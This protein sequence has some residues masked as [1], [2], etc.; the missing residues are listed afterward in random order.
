MDENKRQK[1]LEIGYRIKPSC[2][3]CLHG[4]FFIGTNWGT[5]GIYTYQH[6]KHNDETRQLSIN[7]FGHC[8]RFQISQIES[9]AL[10]KFS[11]FMT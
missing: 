6:L 1:L 4:V 8:H 9:G 7:K 10:D 11:E 5:C 2:G 3:L